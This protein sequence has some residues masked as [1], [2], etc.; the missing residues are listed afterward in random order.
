MSITDEGYSTI[1]YQN[2]SW[3]SETQPATRLDH[4]RLLFDLVFGA[5]A[6]GENEARRQRRKSVLDFA[7]GES[8]RLRRGLG[9][10]DRQKLD[11]HLTA[12][13]QV[14]AR[15][16][17]PDG[18][19]CA[20]AG[21]APALVLPFPAQLRATLDLIVLALRC[22][23]TRVVTF[24]MDTARSGRTFEGLGSHHD[25][26]HHG[27]DP[28]AIGKLLAINEFYAEQ[29]AYLLAAL[30]AA[31]AP[32]GT[33]LLDSAIVLFGSGLSD[34]NQHRKDHLPLVIAGRGN[35]KLSP[36]RVLDLPPNTPLANVHLT[37]LG[38]MGVDRAAFGD[39]TGALPL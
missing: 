3:L 7:A 13:R 17:L 32:D 36:G 27:N 26:S 11:E 10:A 23:L 20:G 21:A 30:K 1:Y 14:E 16:M 2:I 19:T 15:V 28:A 29:L 31:R 4:P 38:H 9:A 33:T 22:D 5:R 25:I 39:S 34:G 12:V 24:M 35:G 37:L 8:D 6:P 18:P